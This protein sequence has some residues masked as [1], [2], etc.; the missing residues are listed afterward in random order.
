MRGTN[1]I[2]ITAVAW[3]LVVAVLVTGIEPAAAQAAPPTNDNFPGASLTSSQV[4]ISGST[5]GATWQRRGGEWIDP[6][7]RAPRTG[8]AVPSLRLGATDDL[9]ASKQTVFAA[10]GQSCPSDSLGC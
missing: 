7:N 9:D 6:C 10:I 4:H 3:T 1:P 2:A 8:E 5:D